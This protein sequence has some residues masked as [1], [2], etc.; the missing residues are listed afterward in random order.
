MNLA[1]AAM[2]SGN[3]N[4]PDIVGQF[5]SINGHVPSLQLNGQGWKPSSYGCAR[6]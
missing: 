6:Q 2:L 4:A 5:Q 3:P 1:R